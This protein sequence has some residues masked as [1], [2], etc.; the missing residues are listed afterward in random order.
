MRADLRVEISIHGDLPDDVDGISRCQR[1]HCEQFIGLGF[2]STGVDKDQGRVEHVGHQGHQVGCRE[3]RV[4]N[5]PEHLPFLSFKGHH[6]TLPEES[7]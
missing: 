6:V 7:I 4:E 2:L 5:G 3:A 1:I